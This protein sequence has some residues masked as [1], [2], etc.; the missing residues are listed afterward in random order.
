MKVQ[1]Y[2]DG[3]CDLHH[4]ER[5]GGWGVHF[6]A[7]SAGIKR[8]MY[9]GSKH[10]T[11][12]LMELEALIVALRSIKN[13]HKHQFDI[14]IDSSYV[15]LSVLNRRE[16]DER[17]YKRVKNVEKLKELYSALDN[18][19]FVFNPND[20][21]KSDLRSIT[22]KNIRLVKVQG[23]SGVRG[24]EIADSLAVLGRKTQTARDSGVIPL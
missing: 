12:N 22:S 24:N 15:L 16:Y 11:N 2:T 13:V 18:L 14:Y 9:G 4:E 6:R 21:D 20:Y 10:T 1:I 23:H 7:D 3:A 8:N 17:G 5:P 19:G